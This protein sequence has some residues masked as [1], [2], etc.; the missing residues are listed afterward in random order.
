MGNRCII[1]Q[2]CKEA[3][4]SI[5]RLAARDFGY[6]RTNNAHDGCSYVGCPSNDNTQLALEIVPI[7]LSSHWR[8]GS[9][10]RHHCPPKLLGKRLAAS[11]ANDDQLSGIWSA[12]AAESASILERSRLDPPIRLDV[13]IFRTDYFSRRSIWCNTHQTKQYSDRAKKRVKSTN[14]SAFLDKRAIGDLEVGS[15]NFLA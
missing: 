1:Y 2:T 8:M 5:N 14:N 4:I 13:C 9:W 11:L 3:L 10:N 7:N 6:S 15:V 12:A